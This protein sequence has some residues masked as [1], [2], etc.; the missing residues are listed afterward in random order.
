MG[1]ILLEGMEFFAYHGHF[2]E[3]QII[4]TKFIVELEIEYDSSTAEKSDKLHDALN[5]QEVYQ[6]SFKRDGCRIP[7]AGTCGKKDPG[8]SE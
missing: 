3:E 8:C 1:T 5:Y 7:F 6:C 2:K 4:G